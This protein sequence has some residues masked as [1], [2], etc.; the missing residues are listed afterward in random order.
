MQET[1][2]EQPESGSFHQAV[3]R[4]S[5]YTYLLG[6]GCGAGAGAGGRDDGAALLEYVDGCCTDGGFNDGALRPFKAG[7]I[8]EKN[9]QLS[10]MASS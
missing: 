10:Y 9:M 8:H 7:V 6:P 5:W 1:T 4:K 2:P 3:I